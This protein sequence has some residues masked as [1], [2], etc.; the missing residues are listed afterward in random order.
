MAWTS[1]QIKAIEEEGT[2]IIV[3]AGAGSGKTAVLT[4]RVLEKV[5]KKIHINELL[6]LTF[7][8]AA[9]AEM[10][11]RIKKN[12]IDE[13]LTDEI[14]KLDTAYITTFDSFAL[15]LVKKYHYLLNIPKNVTITDS[16][17]LNTQKRKILNEIFEEY[18]KENNNEKFKNLIYTLCT[19]DDE[20]L[21][22]TLLNLANKLEIRIDLEEYLEN[23]LEFFYSDEK[24]KEIIR[25]YQIILKEK[26]AELFTT[27]DQERNNFESDYLSKILESLSPLK[28]TEDLDSLLSKIEA[29]K[30][31]I[32]PRGSE[33]KHL[34]FQSYH[35]EAKKKQRMPKKKSMLL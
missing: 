24:I 35:E 21:Q 23:Y 32:L 1:E 26:I 19:K 4:T 13:N 27:I 16:S 30:L 14:N 22:S 33:L 12:L 20:E 3:S 25:D 11:E 7:T 6:I 10:K 29:S 15:S 28:E 34:N 31:P 2:N 18:Y 5:K 8:N 17:I 9:A